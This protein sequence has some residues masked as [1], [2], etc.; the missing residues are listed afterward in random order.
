[1]NYV[2]HPSGWFDNPWGAFD[3][4][5]TTSGANYWIESFTGFLNQTGSR[6]PS[7]LAGSLKRR[8]SEHAV[9]AQRQHHL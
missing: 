6:T 7:L 9:S 1:M 4:T 5:F 8:L 2:K 3:I